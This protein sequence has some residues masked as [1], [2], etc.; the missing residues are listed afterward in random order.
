VK[1]LITGGSGFI[2]KHLVKAILNNK[3]DKMVIID[4]LSNSKLRSFYDFLSTG[5]EAVVFPLNKDRFEFHRVDIQN[6]DAICRVFK[7]HD[8]ISVCIHLAARVNVADSLMDSSSVLPTNVMGT[9][10]IISIAH[11][12][13]VQTFVFSSSAAVYGNA[14][15][16]PI[17]EEEPREPISPYGKSKLL[18]EQ[19]V[20]K[21]NGKFR[22]VRVL[23][24]FNVYGLGQ[25][26]RYA[27]VITRFAHRI[28]NEQP[29]IIYGDGTQT[30]DFISV[31]D[32]TRS[33][34]VAAG[35][36]FEHNKTKGILPNDQ[37]P[38]R[39]CLNVFNVGTG[40]PT[41]ISQ[42]A[43]LMIELMAPHQHSLEPIY[44]DRLEGEIHDSRAD[45][46]RS[47]LILGFNHKDDLRSGLTRM[48]VRMLS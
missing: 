5:N 7:E 30:R 29:P 14:R 11:E 10:N 36:D 33:I 47:S 13:G 26:S 37:I 32:V 20:Q 45:I 46:T 19:L 9:E 8:D 2:G 4:N 22:T 27:G 23:R 1:I 28:S 40:V 3:K 17:G 38:N 31:E 44:E 18:G 21:Y 15:R 16:L 43:S 39:E 35:I 42:L 12:A 48:F 25:T 34:I 41:T 6:K 24:L